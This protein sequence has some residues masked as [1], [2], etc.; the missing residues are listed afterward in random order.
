[1]ELKKTQL[2]HHG[3]GS[4]K[5]HSRMIQRRWNELHPWISVCTSKYRIFCSTCLTANEQGL[6]S[7]KYK[8]TAF[9]HSGFSNWKKALSVF[10]MH[11]SSYMHKD[12]ILKLTARNRG[13]GIDAQL[14]VQLSGDQ[15]HHPSM[16]MKL[17]CA[18]QF[19]AREG[20]PFHGH[21][22]EIGVW[23]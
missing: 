7:P 16:F 18:I 4:K 5:S 9:V 20:L 12:S 15:K 1:M 6:L 13:V 8:Q 23:W 17:L 2:Y 10:R 14:S 11:E 21:K 19:L 3:C 22:E